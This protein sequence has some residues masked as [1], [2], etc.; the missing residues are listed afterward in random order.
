P[1]LLALADRFI[2]SGDSMSML[3]EAAATRKPLQIFEFGSGLVPM[4]GPWSTNANRRPLDWLRQRPA[5][6]VNALCISS[7]PFKLNRGR[8]IRIMQDILIRTRRAVWLGQDITRLKP[9][10]SMDLEHAVERVRALFEIGDAALPRRAQDHAPRRPVDERAFGE[11]AQPVRKART[12]VA[13]SYR[14]CRP[15]CTKLRFWRSACCP[16]SG[17]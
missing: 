5:T 10:Q 4:R 9:L 2:V 7:P 6:I 14:R 13:S 1:A 3:A 8:D 16:T 17:A 11:P 15:C 12:E